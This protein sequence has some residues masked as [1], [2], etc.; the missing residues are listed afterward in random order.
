VLFAI[1]EGLDSIDVG[2]VGV[3]FAV[4]F[5]VGALL[6]R[7]GSRFG[8]FLIAVLVVVEVAAWPMFTRD[9]A[10]DWIIQVPFL[11]IGLVGLAALGIMIFHGVRTKRAGRPTEL[12]LRDQDG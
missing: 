9:T 11:I 10:T 1:G 6:M 8:V 3:V 12:Q 4:L 5:V 2:S 7:S